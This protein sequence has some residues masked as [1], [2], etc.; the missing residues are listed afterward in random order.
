ML[1][2]QV[3]PPSGRFC[4]AALD[5]WTDIGL[6]Y[7]ASTALFSALF[8]EADPDWYAKGLAALRSLANNRGLGERKANLP[9][10]SGKM[11]GGPAGPRQQ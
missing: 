10:M 8:V 3:L 9:S 11:R 7:D 2:R 4:S 1:V 5:S 6:A